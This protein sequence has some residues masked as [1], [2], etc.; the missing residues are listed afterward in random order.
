MFVWLVSFQGIAPKLEFST[1]AVIKETHVSLHD[2][3][4]V[5]IFLFKIN[6]FSH[7]SQKQVFEVVFGHSIW[8]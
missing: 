2:Y 4:L 5:S 7:I 3:E 8:L 6:C 1:R